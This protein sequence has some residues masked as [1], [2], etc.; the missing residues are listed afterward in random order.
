MKNEYRVCKTHRP[1]VYTWN[2]RYWWLPFLWIDP[3]DN[4][5]SIEQAE[6]GARAHAT[7]KK[8]GP[9]VKYLGRLP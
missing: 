4:Y 2:I 8:E 9:I 5:M 1:N 3:N 7:R 6:E